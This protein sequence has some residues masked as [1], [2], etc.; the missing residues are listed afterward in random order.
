MVND[1]WQRCVAFHGHVCP[2]LAI[3]YKAVQIAL[4]ELATGDSPRHRSSA[5]PTDG[6]GNV[7]GAGAGC[8]A[9]G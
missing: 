1:D 6:A 7:F 5:T 4:G 3:G 2:G 9:P 8:A